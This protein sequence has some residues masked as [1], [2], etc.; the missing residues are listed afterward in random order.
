MKWMC[1]PM[2][3]LWLL[4]P[5]AAAQS[6]GSP[7]WSTATVERLQVVNSPVKDYCPTLSFDGTTLYFVSDR[8]ELPAKVSAGESGNLGWRPQRSHDFWFSKRDSSTEVFGEPQYLAVLNTSDNE[9]GLCISPDGTWYVY[10]S[11]PNETTEGSARATCDLMMMS[12]EKDLQGRI[13]WV[14]RK[15]D[16]NT[17]S[18]YWESMPAIGPDYTLYF[19]SDRPGGQ[20]GKDIWFC[21]YDPHTDRW[22]PA[23]NAG[24]M[25]NT[26]K[27]EIAPFVSADG[28]MLIFA[29]KGHK[30]SFGGYDLFVSSLEEG[31]FT[32][33]ENLGEPINTS[34]QE[35]SGCLSVDKT[36]LIFAGERDDSESI[37]IYS[38]RMEGHSQSR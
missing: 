20:G 28:T 21:R 37:D 11:C 15:L 29:S 24:P 9:G 2:L 8:K 13:E 12:R 1:I 4:C 36:L 38:A 19:T 10:V 3:C 35:M 25:I 18:A 7:R 23:E 31:G 26:R 6:V 27:D 22:L 32:K 16:N 34:G 33:P 30:P 5:G 17:N 14:I